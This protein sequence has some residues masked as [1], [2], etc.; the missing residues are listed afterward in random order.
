MQNFS[1]ASK[2]ILP[3]F[4]V[5]EREKMTIF[6]EISSFSLLRLPKKNQIFFQVFQDCGNHVL[7][8]CFDYIAHQTSLVYIFHTFWLCYLNQVQFKN[9][10]AVQRHE[11]KTSYIN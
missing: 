7:S 8:F 9:L 1:Y 4:S 2:K 3:E 11:V 6:P 5:S 10:P